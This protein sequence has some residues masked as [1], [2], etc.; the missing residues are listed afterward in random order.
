MPH[1]MIILRRMPVT[2]WRSPDAAAGDL[3]EN[4]LFRT[5]AA[6]SDTKLSEKMRLRDEGTFFMREHHGVA[7]RLSARN[8]GDFMH[9]IRI[10][11]QGRHD[12][13]AGFM[14]RGD[15]SFLIAHLMALSFRSVADFSL[16]SSR[17]AIEIVFLF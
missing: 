2:C 12:G 13:M 5:A 6:E 10:L 7:A 1:S 11:Q 15:P 8:D 9:R 14:V 4:D 16:A 3:I 17:S